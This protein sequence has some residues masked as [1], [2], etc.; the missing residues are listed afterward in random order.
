MVNET[1]LK[2]QVGLNLID[3]VGCITA[4]KLIAYAGSVEGVFNE[5]KKNLLKIPGIGEQTA[6]SIMNQK[7]LEKAEKEVEF[8]KKFQIK[9]LFYLDKNYPER[10]RNCPDSPLLLYVK[11]NV[12][13]N[14]SKII[15]IVG[16]RNA[17]Q[18]G[19]DITEK[20][21]SELAERNHNPI[22]VSGL[23]YGIDIFAHKAALKNNLPTVAILGHGLRTI[24]P[25]LHKPVAKEIIKNGALVTEFEN[26]IKAD[27]PF[28]VKRNRIIAGISDATIVVES[29]EKGGALITADIANSYNKDVFAFPGRV[30]DTYSRGCNKLIKSNKANLIEN[31]DD[32]EYLLGWNS[33]KKD[34]KVIQKE[35]FVELSD[36]ERKIYNLLKERNEW[37]LDDIC[38]HLSLPVSLISSVLLNLEFSGLVKS[39]P[40]KLYKAL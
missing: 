8:I 31:T 12:N 40:G 18:Y 17:T 9:V 24:Y 19:K 36:D 11:G 38:V 1:A 29:G 25:A 26:D 15:S 3:G 23:A 16:T 14:Q 10:L 30:N 37:I 27:K 34:N 28:F 2:Y 13:F 7:V 33:E 35:L 6:D 5:K 4:K 22:I 39:L 21:I 32:L 20:L